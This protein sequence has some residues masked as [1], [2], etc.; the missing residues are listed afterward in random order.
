ME[1]KLQEFAPMYHTNERKL[2]NY[3]ELRNNVCS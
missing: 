1:V 3:R 2:Q